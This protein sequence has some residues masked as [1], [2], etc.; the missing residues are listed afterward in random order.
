M[1]SVLR[2][3]SQLDARTRYLLVEDPGNANT[4]KFLSG[5]TTGTVDISDVSSNGTVVDGLLKDLGRVVYVY[6]SG[7][8]D[9]SPAGPHVATLRQVQTVNGLATEGVSGDAT[10]SFGSYWIVTWQSG[11][12]TSPLVMGKIGRLG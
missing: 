3:Y 10:N 12:L 7:L 6:D 1:T 2:R 5:A 11:G 4:Y 9:E 8:G